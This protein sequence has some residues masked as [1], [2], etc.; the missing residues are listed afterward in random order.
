MEIKFNRSLLAIICS[1]LAVTNISAQIAVKGKTVYTMS[2]APINNGVVL[3]S[4]GKIEEVGA[5]EDVSIP[6]D[7]RVLSAEVVT[8]GLIDAH[9]VV[10]LSG[11]YNQ[12]HDQDQLE[13]SNPVQPELRAFDAYNHNEALIEYLRSFGVTTIHTGHAPGAL[14]SGQT[15]VVKTTGGLSEAILDSATSV[16]FTLDYSVN[17]NFKKPGTKS[18][19]VSMLRE[20]FIKAQEYAAK[21]ENAEEG[22]EPARNLKLE[23]LAAVLSGDLKA[24]FTVNGSNEI[25]AALRLQKEFGFDLILDSGA[26]CYLLAD[27]IKRAGVPVILHPMMVRTRNVSYTTPSVLRDA[28]I[29]F[30]IQSGYEGY[31]PKTRVVLFEAAVAAANGLSFEQALSSITIDAAKIVGADDHIGSIEEGKDADLV[32]FDG[33]PF[34]YTSH[35]CEVI[36]NGAVVKE[37]CN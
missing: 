4:E 13:K 17:R 30:A 22:K 23:A 34:E 18:K 10:G 32:L 27:D 14:A 12:K 9:S 5:E 24:L 26:E 2:G 1:I 3:I 36:I 29:P 20:D 16:A 8:P 37:G 7:Y 28:G 25:L 19:S 6:G 33:D 35:V 31:V 15:M 21:I 11:I